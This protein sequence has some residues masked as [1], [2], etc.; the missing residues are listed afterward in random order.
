MKKRADHHE[1]IRLYKK[2]FSLKE[3]AMKTDLHWGSIATI[4][5]ANGVDRR[6]IKE[7][8]ALK[9]A[10]KGHGNHWKGGRV[11]RGNGR[12]YIMIWMPA[13]PNATKDGYVMEH[14]LVMEKK[15]GRY[16]RPDEFVH[17]INGDPQ[18]NRSCNLKV[19]SKKGHSR[20]HFDAVKEVATLKAEVARLKKLLKQKGAKR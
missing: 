2:G 8:V 19:T 14:R 10:A 4:L 18:D 16:L 3:V 7:G 5:R 17:H 20:T 1:V 6:S 12:M 13:H 11:L 15:L 9:T